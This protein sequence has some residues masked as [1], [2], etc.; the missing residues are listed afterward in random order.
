[1]TSTKSVRTEGA[2]IVYDHQGDGPLLLMISGGGGDSRRYDAIRPMLAGEYTV[3]SYDRR[4]NSRSTGDAT[5]DLD[6]AQQ[7]RDAVAVIHATGH[8]RAYIFGNSGGASIGLELAARHS[9]VIK[10]L[11]VH[12]PPVMSIL[13]DAE[14]WQGFM[15]NV[16]RTYRQEGDVV[17]AMKAFHSTL[18]GFDDSLTARISAENITPN[19]EFFLTREFLPITYYVP[20]LDRIRRNRVPMVSAAGHASA[21]AYYARTARIIAERAGCP[22]AE[23]PG[24]HIAFITEPEAFA[25]RLRDTL[26]ERARTRRAHPV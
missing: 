1:M 19:S 25:T 8:E 16:Q 26:D 12:E 14:T 3:V 13:P 6:M 22:F 21:D 9:D 15:T 17:A 2:D 7:A 24:N 20:D 18:T 5:L 23:F 10:K 11:V 4:C